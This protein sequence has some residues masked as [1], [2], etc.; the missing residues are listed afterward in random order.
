MAKAA[1]TRFIFLSSCRSAEQDFIYHLA[2]EGIPAVMG[3]LWKV[4]DAKAKEYAD[5]FY[6]RLFGGN[7]RSLE[8]ACLEAKR[9]M[10]ARYE[11]NPIWASPVLL[12]QVGL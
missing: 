11:D 1:K 8:Y 3:F 6:S 9:E 5:T 4:D 7:E 10:H 12:M 2:K